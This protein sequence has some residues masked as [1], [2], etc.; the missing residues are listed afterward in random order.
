MG[1]ITNYII[2]FCWSCLLVSTKEC[3]DPITSYPIAVYS[4]VKLIQNVYPAKDL[5]VSINKTRYSYECKNSTLG[6]VLSTRSIGVSIK[7]RY[8]LGDTIKFTCNDSTTYEIKKDEKQLTRIQDFG[9]SSYQNGVC[10]GVYDKKNNMSVVEF[11]NVTFYTNNETFDSMSEKN[12]F[13]FSEA[14]IYTLSEYPLVQYALLSHESYA[15]ALQLEE[16]FDINSNLLRTYHNA[17]IRLDGY[18]SSANEELTKE[19]LKTFGAFPRKALESMKERCDFLIS[20]R[21]FK[22]EYRLFGKIENYSNIIAFVIFLLA[23]CLTASCVMNYC[24]LR[25]IWPIRN[26]IKRMDKP[27]LIADISSCHQILSECNYEY[28]DLLKTSEPAYDKVVLLRAEKKEKD[29]AYYY[30]TPVNSMIEEKIKY[31]NL[32]HSTVTNSDNKEK[33]QC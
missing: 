5:K 7:R 8:L 32:G 4:E 10:S 25:R 12:T 2:I 23:V 30:L 18:G 6:N 11:V 9:D 33:I 26:Y 20:R 16:P 15:L 29:S 28:I 3:I 24:I 31:A 1:N 19:F 13:S 21:D 17:V 14:R 22:N 27:T